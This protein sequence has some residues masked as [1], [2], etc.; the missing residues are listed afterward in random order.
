MLSYNAVRGMNQGL[1]SSKENE[2]AQIEAN[3]QLQ[4]IRESLEERVANRTYDLERRAVQLQA[5]AEIGHAAA[6]IRDLDELLPQVAHLIS[7]RFGFYHVGI[8]LLDD[9]GEYAILRAANS[10]G[11][12]HMLAREHRLKV[13]EVGI[14]GYATGN[15]EPRIALDVGKD[16]VFFDNPD[17][18]ITRSEMAIPLMV[19]GEVIGALDVQ[20]RREAAFSNEDITMLQVLSDQVAVAI[21]NAR[22]FSEHEAILDSVRRAYGEVSQASWGEY[23]R[24]QSE[25]GFISTRNLEIIPATKDWTPDMIAASQR[26]EIIRANDHCIIVPIVL[27]DQVLG[28]VRLQKLEGARPWSEDEINLMDTIIDQLE[29][30]LESARLYKDTQQRAQRERMV[31]EITTKIRSSTDTQTM[32]QTA[33]SELREALK[34]QRAQMVIQSESKN[35]K[36]EEKIQR[37]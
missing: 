3:R 7:E 26:G 8:F 16:A 34:A 18:P 11:G 24:K 27:R 13:G 36:I 37:D 20:S 9:M 28:V 10:E 2:L 1:R 29:V 31:T 17:L 32:L 35:I 23:L 22:L 33:V 30:A 5:A 4:E 12:Q 21:E 14:V 19:G 25:F 6:T 15:R